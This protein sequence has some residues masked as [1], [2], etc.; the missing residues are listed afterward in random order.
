M[1]K[2]KKSQ[3]VSRQLIT[4]NSQLKSDHK[5]LSFDN[6][7]LNSHSLRKILKNLI[8]LGEKFSK[9]RKIDFVKENFGVMIKRK[10]QKANPKNSL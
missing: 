2:T 9:T 1:Q 3:P 10:M 7:P 8:L 6:I 5:N 4:L